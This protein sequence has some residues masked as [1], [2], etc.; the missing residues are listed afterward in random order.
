MKT[1]SIFCLITAA[2]VSVC[3]AQ[4]SP[5]AKSPH[6]NAATT[7][8]SN[9]ANEVSGSLVE[10]VPGQSLVI[11]TGT[12]NQHF[13]LGPQVQYFNPRGKQIKERKLKKDRKVR[14]HYTK[15]GN[16]MVVDRVTLVRE[17]TGK[18]GKQQKK[19]SPAQQ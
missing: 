12:Q 6:T 3:V 17:G 1:F 10:L 19:Q 2:A 8:T 18:K 5:P 4:P 11:N 13:K 16:D 14:V 9:A 7:T 15:Q